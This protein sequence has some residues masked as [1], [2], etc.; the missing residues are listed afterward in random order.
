MIRQP[1]KRWKAKKWILFI[2]AAFVLFIFRKSLVI[3]IVKVAL[4]LS[5]SGKSSAFTYEKIQWEN[6]IIRIDDISYVNKDAAVLIDQVNIALSGTLFSWQVHCK[7]FHPQITVKPGG[8]SHNAAPLHF[9]LAPQYASAKIFWELHDGIL[10]LDENPPLYFSFLP[11]PIA[12]RKG[13][14][15][16]S[17]QPQSDLSPLFTAVIEEKEE[18]LEMEFSLVEEDCSR[19][20]PIA[21]ALLP[22]TS[23]GMGKK[24]RKGRCIGKIAYGSGRQ[25]DRAVLPMGSRSAGF[26]QCLQRHRALRRAFKRS[27]CIRYSFAIRSTM[28]ERE[29][30]YAFSGT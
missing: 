16:L 13:R 1:K 4:T 10:Q 12:H 8:S 21:M 2:C 11:D 30:Q 5:F 17:Y 28:A 3:G 23:Q 19:L 7:V 18:I 29:G 6:A 15:A 14:M 27:A 22:R 9:L 25:F 20:L 24:T 26:G